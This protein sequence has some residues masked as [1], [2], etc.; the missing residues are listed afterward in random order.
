MQRLNTNISMTAA[1]R[2]MKTSVLEKLVRSINQIRTQNGE[3]YWADALQLSEL[4]HRRFFE[5]AQDRILILN[6]NSEK[7]GAVASINSANVQS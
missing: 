2:S 5:T 3:N 4:R 1:P 6:D 7:T